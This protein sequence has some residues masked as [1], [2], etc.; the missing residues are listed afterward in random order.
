MSVK[1]LIV[2]FR[3]M[4]SYH[5]N[6]LEEHIATIFI[7]EVSQLILYGKINFCLDDESGIFLQDVSNNL[8]HYTVSRQKTTTDR[9]CVALFK[10]VSKSL[11]F[12]RYKSISFQFI[13]SF[14]PFIT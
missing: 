11:P 9:T 13:F 1:I 7:V 8:Q 10:Q 2:D 4:N 12:L 3:V 5:T 14:K 6:N